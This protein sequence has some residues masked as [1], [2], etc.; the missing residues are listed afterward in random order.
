MLSGTHQLDQLQAAFLVE[1]IELA[2]PIGQGGS[3]TVWGARWRSREVAVKVAEQARH[4]GAAPRLDHPG[5]LNELAR[6]RVL[7]RPYAVLDRFPGDLAS[8]LRGGGL[9]RRLQRPVL[10][11]LLDALD[12]AHQ[13]GIVHGDLKPA[14]V[15]VDPAARPVRV[16]LTDFGQAGRAPEAALE[17]SMLSSDRQGEQTYAT[18]AYLAPE[19]LEGGEPSL[20]ADLY[21]FGVLLFELLTGRLPQGLELPSELQRGLDRRFDALVK[22]CL[23]RDPAARPAANAVRREVLGLCPPGG[24]A[25]RAEPSGSAREENRV[26]EGMVLIPGGFLVVGDRDEPSARPM[27]E[28][29]ISPFWIDRHPVT[30]RRYLAYVLATKA[31]RPP[32]W[33]ERGRLRPQLLDLP[34]TG[35]DWDEAL[36]FARWEGK[37]LPTEFE[38]ERAA[39][40][41]EQ[42][43]QPY[44][45]VFDPSQVQVGLAPV[46]RL[47]A[48][49]EGVCD[50]TGNGWEWTA[51]AFGPYPNPSP[52]TELRTLRGGLNPARGHASAHL[53][54]GLR[55]DARDALVTF[56]CARDAQQK[57]R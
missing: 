21:S 2:E 42:R 7:G 27:H 17:A 24:K 4:L 29:Q 35:V 31:K 1:G 41:P 48:S 22:R 47:G 53:R 13:R 6:G 46:G 50:L 16:A 25:V 39:Q 28:R 55:R 38:W 45:E 36:A 44:G 34:V 9:P 5:I 33:P 49:S 10:L 8:L 26:E 30:N 51:S 19:R 12:F 3:A 54:A 52:H 14:N 37:R 11:Q 40:G 20:A 43:S 15:L 56:R 32:S 57:A 23:A 18:L